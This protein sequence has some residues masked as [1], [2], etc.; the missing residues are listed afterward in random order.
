[1]KNASLLR[2]AGLRAKKSFGQN[3]LEDVSAVRR[4]ADAC[5]LKPGTAAVEIGAGLGALTAV[6]DMLGVRWLK[7][8][9]V[10]FKVSDKIG[11]E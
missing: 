5:A 7:S 6:L 10:R 8:R 2:D 11:R 1:M 4:I 9:M 3:F